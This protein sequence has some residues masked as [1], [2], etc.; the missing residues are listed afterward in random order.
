MTHRPLASL[1]LL[2]IASAVAVPL[3]GCADGGDPV[4]LQGGPL[5]G[6]AVSNPFSVGSANDEVFARNSG[7]MPLLT[8]E[9]S[10]D[11][12]TPDH[13]HS[14]MD[15]IGSITGSPATQ[16]PATASG[17]ANAATHAATQAAAD[18]G[19]VPTPPGTNSEEI[20]ITAQQKAA[21]KISITHDNEANVDL[22][23][24]CS[25]GIGAVTLE[26]V[27]DNWPPL[28]RL[29]LSY[30]KEKPFTRLEGLEAAEISA[31][32]RVA[33][34]TTLDKEAGKGQVTIPGFSRAQQIQI[35]WVDAYR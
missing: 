1:V 8:I 23:I 2:T 32:K 28:I 4:N 27:G 5:R 21:D 12:N 17:P 10:G 25:S 34:K 20:K 3:S 9:F 13:V 33:L 26:R 24:T 16:A 30:D 11:R 29:H 18:L 19:L 14:V 7:A 6:R 31:D 22:W 35:Q 15:D